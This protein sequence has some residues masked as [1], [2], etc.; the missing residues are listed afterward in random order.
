MADEDAAVAADI[1]ARV[2][3]VPEHAVAGA[4]CMAYGHSHE[5]QRADDRDVGD[6]VQQE[7]PRRPQRREDE[8]AERRADRTCSVE[9]RRVQR[10]RVE[11]VLFGHELRDERLP[12]RDVE[13]RDHP[14][15]EHDSHERTGTA[16][17]GLPHTQRPSAQNASAVCVVI[18]TLRR[19]NRSAIA[20]DHG[21]MSTPGMNWQKPASPTHAA[22]SVVL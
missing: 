18:S 1:A 9:L 6:R 22:L 3:E 12:R 17:P 5:P 4:H 11:Q 21:P 10:D 7:R 16:D 19:S 8:A 2:D 14:G 13:C 20:P 15:R